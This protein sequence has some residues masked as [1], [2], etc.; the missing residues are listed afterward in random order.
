MCT[1]A[2]KLSSTEICS[3]FHNTLIE[4][5]TEVSKK[6]HVKTVVLSGGC[7]YNTVLVQGIKRN[8]ENLGM[9]VYIQTLYLRGDEGI[10]LGQAAGAAYRLIG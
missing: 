5:A 3:R 6:A 8:L 4:V 2:K 1:K 9:R 10:S 7:F